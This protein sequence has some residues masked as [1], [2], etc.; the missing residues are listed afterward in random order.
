MVQKL[1]ELEC[2]LQSLGSSARRNGEAAEIF[3]SKMM[4]NFG[5]C[6]PANIVK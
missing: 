2:H 1:E 5:G 4:D 6:K 3:T